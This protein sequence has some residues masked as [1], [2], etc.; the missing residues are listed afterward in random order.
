MVEEELEKLRDSQRS[1]EKLVKENK[2]LRTQLER[3]KAEAALKKFDLSKRELQKVNERP[4]YYKEEMMRVLTERNQLKETL[5]SRQEELDELREALR[6]ATAAN[7]VVEVPRNRVGG[8]V[9]SILTESI[10]L[11]NYNIPSSP[12]SHT[13]KLISLCMKHVHNK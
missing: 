6:K 10:S 7:G 13:P 4:R 8:S 12:P 5:L 2:E 3:V 11:Q 1:R 9:R